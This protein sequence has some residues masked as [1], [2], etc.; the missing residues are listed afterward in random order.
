[1]RLSIAIAEA[2]ERACRA[3]L[4]APKPGNVHVFADGHAMTVTDFIR[5]AAAAAPFIAWEGASVGKRI[6]DAVAATLAAVGQNT[7]LG[8]VLLCAPLAASIERQSAD[9][10]TAIRL[11]LA[12]LDREDARLAFEAITRAAPGGLGRAPR[13]DVRSP[14]RVSL[15]AAM[16]EAAERDR[17]ARQYATGFSDVFDIGLA[18]LESARQRHAD[19]RF[20]TLG[21]YLT[22]LSAFPDTHIVRRQGEAIAKTVMRKAGDARRNFDNAGSLAELQETLAPWDAAL[23]RD[24]INPGTSADLTVA[25]LFAFELL[26]IL[27]SI[28]KS[29]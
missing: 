10:R 21:V 29:D 15:L 8:I 28:R 6:F 22:F 24:G 25:T 1:M 12:A 18:A 5:S 4:E 19:T 26:G 3:E 13:H 17:V 27:R 16:V 11:T 9:L 20:A 7:N 2:F 23:K 14:P